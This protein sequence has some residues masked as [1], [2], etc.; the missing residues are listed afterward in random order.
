[1]EQV[2]KKIIES[3]AFNIDGVAHVLASF[4]TREGFTNILK[5][6][7]NGI[8]NWNINTNYLAEYI[9]KEYSCYKNPV[10]TNV[11]CNYAY[12]NIEVSF[13]YDY[14]RYYKTEN[15][16]YYDDSRDDEQGDYIYKKT[17][18]RDYSLNI[19]YNEYIN[20]VRKHHLESL[21]ELKEEE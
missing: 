9:D 10:I 3:N 19:F 20:F 2:F 18:I 1:M 5:L 15:A 12:S 13:N 14:T 8:E 11:T 4:A 16:E 21:N 7:V 6:C 17:F